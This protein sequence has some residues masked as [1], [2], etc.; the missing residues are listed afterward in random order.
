MVNVPHIEVVPHCLLPI[1][2]IMREHYEKCSTNTHKKLFTNVFTKI[3]TFWWEH[4]WEHFNNVLLGNII[5]ISYNYKR[6]SFSSHYYNQDNSLSKSLSTEKVISN[7]QGWAIFLLYRL[8][9]AVISLSCEFP[10]CDRPP[11]YIHWSWIVSDF[12]LTDLRHSVW[13]P[14]FRVISKSVFLMS[15]LDITLPSW[16]L[17]NHRLMQNPLL[18]LIFQLKS[19]KKNGQHRTR[20]GVFFL[21]WNL[22]QNV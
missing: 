15:L 10:L 19:T 11:F 13:Y 8:I 2:N 14:L 5:K 9:G 18:F 3:L 7:V 6:I 4:F 16:N 12:V 1:E 21:V 22:D 17:G 20:D